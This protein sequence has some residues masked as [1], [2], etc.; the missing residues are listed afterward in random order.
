MYVLRTQQANAVVLS[1]VDRYVCDARVSVAVQGPFLLYWFVAEQ[2]NAIL[3]CV[4]YVPRVAVRLYG[5]HELRMVLLRP[6]PRVREV[7]EEMFKKFG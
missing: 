3:M 5:R 2:E 6:S 1:T 7:I 4:Q